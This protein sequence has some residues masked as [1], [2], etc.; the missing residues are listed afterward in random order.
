MDMSNTSRVDMEAEGGGAE[1]EEWERFQGAKY[2]EGVLRV[3]EGLFIPVGYS[4]YSLLGYIFNLRYVLNNFTKGVRE[5]GA[6][7]LTQVCC[8]WWWVEFDQKMRYLL[9][10]S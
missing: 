3:G 7:N 5:Y 4:S 8:H 6:T 9:R 1:V 2:S 10:V